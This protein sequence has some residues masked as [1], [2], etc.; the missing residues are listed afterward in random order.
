MMMLSQ[1]TGT[2]QL[3]FFVAVLLSFEGEQ[4]KIPRML[5]LVVALQ[6]FVAGLAVAIVC[7]VK[8]TLYFYLINGMIGMLFSAVVLF[9]SVKWHRN[10]VVTINFFLK[11]TCS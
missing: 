8:N 4:L 6:P 2:R 3:L 9:V 10:L 11:N 5:N 7:Y 1:R